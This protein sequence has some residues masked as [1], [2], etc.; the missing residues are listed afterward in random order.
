MR[1]MYLIPVLFL[2]FACN[3]MKKS[4]ENKDSKS[5]MFSVLH[6]SNYQGRENESNVVIRNEQE[7]KKLYQSVG[8][9]KYPE[10]DF[11]KNQVAA[12][13]LGTK[14]SGGYSVSVERVEENET[15]IIIYKKIDAPKPG[16]NVTM[17]LTNPFVIVEIYSKKEIVFK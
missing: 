14:T 5:A 4:T 10:I 2:V 17:A 11:N 8:K 1:K 6:S 15:Q 7:L 12:L 3:C 16:E 13:F 9:E